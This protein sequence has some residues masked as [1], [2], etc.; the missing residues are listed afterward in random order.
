MEKCVQR[1]LERLELRFLD[2]REYFPLWFF[3]AKFM[4]I[5]PSMVKKKVHLYS[6]SYYKR[7]YD[8]YYSFHVKA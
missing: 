2:K 3:G 5:P 1:S 6:S 7:F 8:V 4:V